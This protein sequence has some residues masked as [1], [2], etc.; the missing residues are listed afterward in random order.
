MSS[1]FIEKEKIHVNEFAYS[2]YDSYPVSKGHMLVVPK[3]IVAEIFDLTNDEYEGCFNLVKTVKNY[4]ISEYNPDG[5]NIGSNCGAAAGQTIFHAHI[6]I[7]P[8]YNGDIENPKGGLR[9]IFP[10][11]GEY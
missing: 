2:F 5:F 10:G 9:N 8:R 1:P 3:R 4:L 6:H 7:I 11:K